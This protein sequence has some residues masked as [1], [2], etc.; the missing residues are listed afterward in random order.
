MNKKIED[1]EQVLQTKDDH[2]RFLNKQIQIKNQ[3]LK[4]QSTFHLSTQERDNRKQRRNSRTWIREKAF[5]PATEIKYLSFRHG[6]VVIRKNRWIYAGKWRT[7][8]TFKKHRLPETCSSSFKHNTNQSSI[9]ALHHHLQTKNVDPKKYIEQILHFN[10]LSSYTSLTNFR[11]KKDRG[12]YKCRICSSNDE[13]I[14]KKKFVFVKD[15]LFW[16]KE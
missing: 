4:T 14:P 16:E 2:I 12:S 11:E 8:R 9:E 13:I 6:W 5:W 1:F 3:L 7:W 15:S 10:L